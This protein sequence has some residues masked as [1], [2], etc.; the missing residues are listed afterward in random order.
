VTGLPVRTLAAAEEDMIL[1]G[2]VCLGLTMEIIIGLGY[3][4]GNYSLNTI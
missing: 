4:L 1:I 2:E 3:C